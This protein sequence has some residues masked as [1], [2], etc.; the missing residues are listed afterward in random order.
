LLVLWSGLGWKIVQPEPRSGGDH[1]EAVKLTPA[2]D[3]FPMCTQN[4]TANAGFGFDFD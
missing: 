3:N 4:R 1:S 2:T